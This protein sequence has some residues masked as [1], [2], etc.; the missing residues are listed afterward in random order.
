MAQR[1]GKTR[2]FLIIFTSL[3]F[4]LFII[5]L[6]FH[7]LLYN[8]DFIDKLLDK[9]SIEEAKQPTHQLI[10]YFQ[11]TDDI[12]DVFQDEKEIKHLEDVK[13]AINAS[14]LLLILSFFI[15]LL[16]ILFNKKKGIRKIFLFS[17]S[18]VFII[19]ILLI[20]LP[21]TPLFSIF[22]EILFSPGS[23]LFPASSTLIKFYPKIFF[24]DFTK[25]VI[26]MSVITCLPFVLYEIFHRIKASKH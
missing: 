25:S 6:N 2:L 9:H 8:P 14:T 10:N 4:A 16:F 1:S 21:F 3:F 22:H 5:L 15:V 13:K 11:G 7:A 26:I 24:Q 17:H 19:A 23:W 20:I 18:F 12:P